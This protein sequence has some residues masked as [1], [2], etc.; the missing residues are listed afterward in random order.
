MRLNYKQKFIKLYAKSPSK[1]QRAFDR[2]IKLFKN[3]PNNRLL[4]NHNLKG[5]YGGLRSINITGDWRAIFKQTGD[6]FTFLLLD[7]HSNLYK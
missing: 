5:K 2:R 6:L 3:E 7:T 4:N 1:I